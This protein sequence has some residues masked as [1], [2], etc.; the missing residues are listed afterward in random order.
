MKS[1]SACARTPPE[2]ISTSCR[3][4]LLSFVT[5]LIGDISALII[6]AFNVFPYEV[7]LDT[8]GLPVG[9]HL[10][11]VLLQE[12]GLE[13]LRVENV[14]NPVCILQA[15]LCAYWLTRSHHRQYGLEHNESSRALY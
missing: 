13:R 2:T 1:S 6:H 10:S 14:K 3:A 5:L 7:V 4:S 9:F 12:L 11:I 8:I 15:L